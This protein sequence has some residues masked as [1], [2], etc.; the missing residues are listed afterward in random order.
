[1][2]NVRLAVL[3]SLA[4]VALG[5]HSSRR[6]LVVDSDPPGALVVLDGQDSGFATPCVIDLE[7]RRVE[8]VEL[9]LAGYRTERRVL[10]GGEWSQ[11]MLWRDMSVG[12]H[13]WRF[14]LFLSTADVLMPVKQSD[15]E[16]PHR[17]HARLVRERAEPGAQ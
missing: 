13:A 5:C 2:P 11:A 16:T 14:P 15:G 17:I 10:E 3:A 1:M 12:I 6:P 9:V 4:A 8:T 7:D